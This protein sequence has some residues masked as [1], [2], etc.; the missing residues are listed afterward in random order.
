MT[1]NQHGPYVPGYT[2]ATMG[3]TKRSQTARWSESHQTLSQFGLGSATRPYEVG[4][5]SNRAS[6]MAR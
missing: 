1:S 4:I 3:G 6:A 2:G 5:A